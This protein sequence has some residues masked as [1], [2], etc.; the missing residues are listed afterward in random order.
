MKIITSATRYEQELVTHLQKKIDALSVNIL[1]GVP[2]DV[3]NVRCAELR[4]L[5]D[6]LAELPAI[7]K[8]AM[9]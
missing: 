4:T 9:D 5:T 2:V 1:R 6:L 3:Y 7:L 8:K